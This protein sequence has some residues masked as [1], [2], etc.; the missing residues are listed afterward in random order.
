VDGVEEV[1]LQQAAFVVAGLG[2]GVRVREKEAV[3]AVVGQLG[4]EVAGVAQEEAD[5]GIMG[6]GDYGVFK[7]VEK[8]SNSRLVEFAA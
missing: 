7:V 6:C 4:E 8:S 5:L 2:P 1:V 3:D